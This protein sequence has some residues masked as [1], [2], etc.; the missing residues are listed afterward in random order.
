MDG[1]CLILA[2]MDDRTKLWCSHGWLLFD[3]G[4][5]GSIA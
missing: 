2:I 1:C 3:P 4:Y 5:H